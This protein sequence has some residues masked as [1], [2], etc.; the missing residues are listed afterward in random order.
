MWHILPP[1]KHFL[2]LKPFMKASGL[3]HKESGCNWY[4][5]CSWQQPLWQ[6]RYTRAWPLVDRVSNI[7]RKGFVSPT[8]STLWDSM[9]DKMSSLTNLR[10]N[11]IVIDIVCNWLCVDGPLLWND[12]DQ[13]PNLG[14]FPQ[15]FLQRC[16]QNVIGELL[17]GV[18][19]INAQKFLPNWLLASHF[20]F[21]HFQWDVCT[22]ILYCWFLF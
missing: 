3:C 10:K 8:I 14:Y 20:V 9:Q 16:K 1:I 17:P 19:L 11:P 13:I 4:F 18:C 7:V 22:A 2:L 15:V 5:L 12:I 6:A 21:A